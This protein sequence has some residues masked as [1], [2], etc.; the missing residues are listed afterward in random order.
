MT[1]THDL[2]ALFATVLVD[3]S[4]SHR[5]NCILFGAGTEDRSWDEHLSTVM[6]RYDELISTTSFSTVLARGYDQHFGS[7]LHR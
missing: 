7:R 4:D 2:L 1:Q 6:M 5:I 3:V